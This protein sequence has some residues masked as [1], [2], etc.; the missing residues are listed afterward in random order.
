MQLRALVGTVALALALIAAT[1]LAHAQSAKAAAESAFRQG[2]ALMASGDLPAACTAFEESEKLDHQL[3]TQY[4]LARCYEQLGKLTSAWINFSEVAAKDVR[5]GRKDD[6]ARRAKSLEPRLTRIVIAVVTPVPGEQI[7][8]GAIDVSVL[9]G[10]PLPIDEG[11]YE[12]TATAPGYD[13][14]HGEVTLRGPGRVIPIDVPALVRSADLLPP[15]EPRPPVIARRN[16]GHGRRVAGLLIGGAGVI[17]IG[18]GGYFGWQAYSLEGEAEDA[19]GGALASCAKDQVGA[20]Q[21]LIN[22]ARD[23]ATLADVAIGAG[24]AIA[25]GGAILYLTAP[26]GETGVAPVIGPDQ[27][28]LSFA[29]RF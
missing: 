14:W 9:A 15:D 28:G 11:A 27:V 5:G 29:G 10:T 1:P 25:I 6:S 2:K 26:D 22:Q 12:V 24:A 19:C 7:R 3:G 8:V 4:N 23:Q 13:A 17:A 21:G 18:V 16:P 20:A